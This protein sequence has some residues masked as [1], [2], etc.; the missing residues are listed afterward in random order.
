MLPLHTN[1]NKHKERLMSS[2]SHL[3]AQRRTMLETCRLKQTLTLPNPLHLS[4]FITR[5]H[6]TSKANGDRTSLQNKVDPASWLKSQC[7]GRCTIRILAETRTI[8][9]QVSRISPQYLHAYAWIDSIIWP[10]P[11][12]STFTC[13]AS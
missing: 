11:L 2:D 5:V 7:S 10:L 12:P 4:Q 1:Y 8:P 3:T 13:P 6:V 9:I